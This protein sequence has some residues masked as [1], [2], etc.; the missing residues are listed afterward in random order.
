MKQANI[1][2]SFAKYVSLNIIG[3]MGLSCYILADTFFVAQGVGVNGLTALN[4]AIP[5]Y[6]F[7]NGTGLMIGIGGATRFA[8]SKSKEAFT[9]SL[10]YVALASCVFLLT[11]I[12]FSSQLAV[13]LGADIDTLHNTTLYLKTIL[14]FSPM[15]LLNNVIICFVRNDGSPQLAMAAMLIGSFSN[16]VLDYIFIFPFEMG[17]FGA[18]LA[19]GIAPVVSLLCLSVHFVKKQNTFHLL[20]QKLQFKIFADISFL[21][22]SA[23]ITELSSGL[24]IIV[25][26]AIILRIEGNIGVAAYGIIANIALV[27]LAIFTGIAQGMQPI[28]SR[29]IGSQNSHDINDVLKLGFITTISIAVAV[30]AI[31]FVFSDQIV[32]AFN[33]EGNTKLAEI[34][35]QGLRIYFTSF[36][37]SGINILSA[38]SF[39]SIDAPKNAFI[40]SILRG[41]VVLIPATMVLSILFGITGVWLSMTVTE[42]IVLLLSLVM[43]NKIRR[44]NL[45]G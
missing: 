24:V 16:I 4:L 9:Q 21:G 38:A 27:I 32:A 43:V 1:K 39:S 28:I 20:L 37:F 42:V 19:T 31:S 14:C 30:Y 34:A 15:F 25:F 26:N 11:G 13:T 40:I 45:L 6:S 23:F 3:M 44:A 12:F 17:L 18:A 35:I 29:C 8:I 7:I 10:Y 41:C 5:V 2:R 36:V 33:N 22:L